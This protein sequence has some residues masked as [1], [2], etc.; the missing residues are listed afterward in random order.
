[1][2]G[3]SCLPPT[4]VGGFGWPTNPLPPLSRPQGGREGGVR[5]G[6]GL[7]PTKVGGKQE[8]PASPK[9]NNTTGNLA[10]ACPSQF[11]CPR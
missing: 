7:P 11:Y 8:V 5:E 1:M 4:S 2:L 9:T 10:Q 3:F 6:R